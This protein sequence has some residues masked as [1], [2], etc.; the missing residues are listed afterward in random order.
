MIQAVT[1]HFHGKC[2][3]PALRMTFSNRHITGAIEMPL[4]ANNIYRCAKIEK[5]FVVVKE[6]LIMSV[7][8]CT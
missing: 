2:A 8:Q 5:L 4:K 3:W 1:N 7:F 6:V